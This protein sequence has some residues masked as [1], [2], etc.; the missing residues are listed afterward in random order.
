MSKLACARVSKWCCIVGKI[1]FS[2]RFVISSGPRALSGAILLI[3]FV[4]CCKVILVLHCTAS[5]YSVESF[6]SVTS[7]DG[8]GGK[9]AVW[10][11]AAFSS[12]DAATSFRV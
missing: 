8:G 10:N 6:I 2:T 12:F 4:I 7:V 5:G 11:S 9:N 1:F 3:A